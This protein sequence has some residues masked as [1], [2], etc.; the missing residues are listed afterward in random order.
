MTGARKLVLRTELGEGIIVEVFEHTADPHDQQ[1]FLRR[2]LVDWSGHPT[3]IASAEDAVITKTRWAHNLDRKKDMADVE[4]IIGV[5]G[6][7]LDWGYV[8]SW[9][10]QHGSRGL[11]DELRERVRRRL[12]GG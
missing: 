7:Q 4:T 3:W 1:R 12:A 6:D 9:C 11:L 2:Q 8:E 5:R 10:D